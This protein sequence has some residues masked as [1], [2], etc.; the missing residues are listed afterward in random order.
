MKRCP[1]CN[2]VENDDALAFCRVD[3]AALVGDSS[4]LGGEAGTARLGSAPAASEVETSI[5]PHSREAAMSRATAPTTALPHGQS[6]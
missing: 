5:L 1:R 6:E 2:R 4:P 3:G